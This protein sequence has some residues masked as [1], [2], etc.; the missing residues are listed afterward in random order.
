MSAWLDRPGYIALGAAAVAAV[1]GLVVL[2]VLL[3]RSGG[4]GD[5]GSAPSATQTPG[6][7]AAAAAAS[8]T[9]APNATP[10][11]RR[12]AD[13]DGALNAFV[14]EQFN[15][16]YIGDCPRTS[17]PS[18]T[19]AGGVCSTELYRSVELVTF[20]LGMPFSEAFG[21]AVLTLGTEGFWFVDF[22]RAPAPEQ[23][24][25]DGGEAVVYGAGSCLNFRGETQLAATVATCQLDGTAA[26]VVDG[27]VVA[28]GIT[29]WQLEGYGWASEEFLASVRP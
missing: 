28:E 19:P 9:G 20:F 10:T 8:P 4:G 25:E 17:L 26:R 12:F 27:P 13:P 16:E 1:A 21:E 14:R 22:V 15:A 7:T 3:V 5:G 24:I 18:A 11:A 23:Q 29:W 6:G 2:I